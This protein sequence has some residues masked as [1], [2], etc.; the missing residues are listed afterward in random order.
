M[1]YA[2][3]NHLINHFNS[4]LI[5]FSRFDYPSWSVALTKTFCDPASNIFNWTNLGNYH[6]FR[7]NFMFLIL[8]CYFAFHP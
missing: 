3:V 6:V 5:S 2:K 4:Y 1:D 7:L 8:N